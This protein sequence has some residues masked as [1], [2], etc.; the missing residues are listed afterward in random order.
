VLLRRASPGMG[1]QPRQAEEG[2][3]R[4]PKDKATQ[5]KDKALRR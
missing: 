5:N 2:F 1:A 4:Q 3:K